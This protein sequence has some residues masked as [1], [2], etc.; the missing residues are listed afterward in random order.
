MK[1]LILAV[2]VLSI[3]LTLRTSTA[4]AQTMFNPFYAAPTG[5]GAPAVFIAGQFGRGINSESGENNFVGGKITVALPMVSLWAEGGPVFNGSSDVTLG[6]GLAINFIQVPAAPVKLTLQTGVGWLED[7]GFTLLK[8]PVGLAIQGNIPSP[9]ADVTPWVMPRVGILRGSGGGSSN[10][11]AGIGISAGIGFTLPGGFG[12]DAAL[13]W[14]NIDGANP[15]LAG[16]GF[17]YKFGL[18]SP[19]P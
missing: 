14:E 13:D 12:L 16:V 7:G 4:N 18:P 15:L 11:E 5:T 9:G 1:Q 8:V 19:M 17:H 10:T 3:G 2:T 6:A